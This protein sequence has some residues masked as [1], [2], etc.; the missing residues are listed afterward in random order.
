MNP[1]NFEKQRKRLFELSD[2]LY[3]PPEEMSLAEAEGL[4]RAAG[5]EPDA[6]LDRIRERLVAAENSRGSQPDAVTQAIEQ[7]RSRTETPD[8]LGEAQRTIARLLEEV[9]RLP[10]SF[11]KAIELTFSAAYR[12]NTGLSENDKKILDEAA[13]SLKERA[14]KGRNP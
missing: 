5:V 14:R 10:E 13:E 11:G 6:V 9:R 3:G 4:L 7:L 12:K 8:L 2:S 1:P